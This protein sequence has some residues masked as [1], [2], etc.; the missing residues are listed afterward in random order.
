MK[1]LKN[2]KNNNSSIN[3]NWPSLK[4]NK[5]KINSYQQNNQSKLEDKIQY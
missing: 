5:Q 2:Y 4:D 3:K 1:E